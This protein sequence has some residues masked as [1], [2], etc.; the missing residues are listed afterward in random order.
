MT[1]EYEDKLAKD[2]YSFSYNPVGFEIAFALD[3][4]SDLIYVPY[5]RYLKWINKQIK[6]HY[7]Y[8]KWLMCKN[9][10]DPNTLSA[11]IYEA[12]RLID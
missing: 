3:T 1:Q 7:C 12:T 6:K 2:E 8:E 5:S 10:N 4:F 11:R 9:T